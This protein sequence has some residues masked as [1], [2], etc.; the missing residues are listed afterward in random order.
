M[1][2]LQ[3]SKEQK[4][5]DGFDQAKIGVMRRAGQQDIIIYDYQRYVEILMEREGWTDEEA[6]EWMEHNV[7]S[8]WM[9]EGTPGFVYK[10]N[11]HLQH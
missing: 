11:L 4:T 1:C 8:A 9:G 5:A 6:E 3:M 7:L 2:S 10:D